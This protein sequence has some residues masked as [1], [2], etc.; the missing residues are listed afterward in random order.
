[1]SNDNRTRNP[2]EP[3]G[4]DPNES[5]TEAYPSITNS[6]TGPNPNIAPPNQSMNLDASAAMA[7]V[8]ECITLQQST[9]HIPQFD[10]KNPPLKEFLQDI[11]NGAVYIT[12]STEPGFIKV[13]LSK[14]KGVARESVR[15][16]RFNR[17]NDLMA[18]LKKHFAPSKKY[19]WYF[20]SIVNLRMKQTETVSD[21][22][23]RLQGLLSGA[24][25]AI[26]DKYT[27]VH[28][29]GTPHEISESTI[30]MKPVVDCALDAFIKGLPDEISTFVDTI[31][32]KDL[33]EALEHALHIEERLRQTERLRS[34]ASSY[35][36][37]RQNEKGKKAR[38][39]QKSP[40]HAIQHLHINHFINTRHSTLH[41]HHSSPTLIPHHTLQPTNTPSHTHPFHLCRNTLLNPRIETDPGVI[42]HGAGI[43]GRQEP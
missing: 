13:V 32:P 42:N 33:S 31:N 1:M 20:E 25:H 17:V 4:N 14:L 18:H 22:Y 3:I 29:A 36:I 24:K 9:Y 27:Q 5:S 19:Q 15:D 10:G 21:Y 16:K 30:M 23:D 2:K 41:T 37:M 39:H 35:H 34:S 7:S 43:V 26:E 12:E 28:Y 8:L 11:A 6:L 40:T 38:L